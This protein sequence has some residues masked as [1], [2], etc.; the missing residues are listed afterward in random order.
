MNYS[1]FKIFVKLG[2]K[3]RFSSEKQK[4][5]SDDGIEFIYQLHFLPDSK[6]GKKC[7]FFYQILN[8]EKTVIGRLTQY[9]A[10]IG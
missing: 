3:I 9:K 6:F 2:R 7:T 10:L 5:M 4:D 1:L 8:L